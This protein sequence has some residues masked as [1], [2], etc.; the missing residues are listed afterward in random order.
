MT[1]KNV[2]VI[3]YFRRNLGDDLFLKV[4][5]ERYEDYNFIIVTN[6][7]YR[8]FASNVRNVGNR[9]LNK[10]IR[11]ATQEKCTLASVCAYFF[12]TVVFLGGSIFMEGKVRTRYLIRNN[13]DYYVLGANFGPYYTTDFYEFYKKFFSNS[14]DVCF[15]DEYSCSLFSDVDSVRCKPDVVF[16]LKSQ[17]K[18][19]SH[20]TNTVVFSIIDASGRPGIN[21]K[22]YEELI[23]DLTRYFMNKGFKIIYMSFCEEEGD[24]RAI[25][26]IIND[27][28]NRFDSKI[29]K[30][31][32]RNNVNEAVEIIMQSKI[33]VGSRYHANV[34]GLLFNK[35]ILPIAYSDKLCNELSDLHYPGP[36]YDL[37][38]PKSNFN[39]RE[40]IEES[41]LSSCTVD[42]ERIVSESNKNFDKLDVLLLE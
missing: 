15:R 5:S 27:A 9:V 16:G 6:S 39:F 19:L 10:I 20:D 42:I 33:V 11:I 12:D 35:K 1:R 13:A 14:I 7:D 30:I 21:S 18:V 34:L 40:F 38:K 25:E 23:F 8:G 32:Y 28:N 4:I 37:R 17:G 24:E 26:R 31:Y 3:G 29:E 36:I 22:D 41:L 2:L